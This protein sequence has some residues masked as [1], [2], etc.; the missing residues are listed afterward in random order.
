MTTAVIDDTRQ[1]AS[2]GLP[3]KDDQV[4]HLGDV[5]LQG[6]LT[7]RDARLAYKTY[8]EL[9]PAGDNAVLMPTFFGGH[10]PDSELMMAPGRALDPARW[11]VIVPNVLG[12]GLSSSPSNTPAPFDGPSF[13][14]V[15]VY[16]NVRCQH[17]LVTE[18]LGVDHL[19]L[20][21][22]FSMGAQQAFHW[23]ALYPEMMDAIAPICGSA[24]TSTGGSGISQDGEW[25]LLS[26]QVRKRRRQPVEVARD[27]HSGGRRLACQPRTGSCVTE[28][29]VR[30]QRCRNGTRLGPYRPTNM[31]RRPVP[32]GLPAGAGR[33]T[34]R[35][36]RWAHTR[37]GRGWPGPGRRRST[38]QGQRPD[39]CERP[40]GRG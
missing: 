16:D 37:R 7:L 19:R 34:R 38:A 20:V 23:G 4:F 30:R 2:A 12:N 36:A 8:G 13:P 39:P 10:H 27:Q 29:G 35:W 25:W 6:G 9:S 31:S 1:D 32:G 14:T 40:G 3:Q 21:V 5:V 26:R 33:R 11:F 22:G 18:R 24:R 17:R 28:V 15:T